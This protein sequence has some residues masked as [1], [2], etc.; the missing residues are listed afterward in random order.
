M[1]FSIEVKMFE[2]R[3]LLIIK[4]NK[5]QTFFVNKLTSFVSFTIYFD[6]FFTNKFFISRVVVFDSIN[7]ITFYDLTFLKVL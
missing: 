3:R 2:F 4:T 5:E 7:L 1:I 6:S